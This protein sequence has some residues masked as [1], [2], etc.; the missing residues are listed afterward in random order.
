MRPRVTGEHAGS[1]DGPFG[2]AGALP[3][4]REPVAVAEAEYR[5]EMYNVW[6]PVTVDDTEGYA[7]LVTGYS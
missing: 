3:R 1:S 4:D 7:H 6:I 5:A 2:R